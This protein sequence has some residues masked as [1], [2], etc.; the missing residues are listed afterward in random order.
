MMFCEAVHMETRFDDFFSETIPARP[1]ISSVARPSHANASIRVP[2]CSTEESLDDC[3]PLSSS[4]SSTMRSQMS[5]SYTINEFTYT[6]RIA[7]F[8]KLRTGIEIQD[9]QHTSLALSQKIGSTALMLAAEKAGEI[10]F[11]WRLCCS[12]SEVSRP[13]QYEYAPS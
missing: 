11:R 1:I 4:S 9:K 6:V 5:R 7:N 2:P 12:P 13:T 3:G 8:R 10:I